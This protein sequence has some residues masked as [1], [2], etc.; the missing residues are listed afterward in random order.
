[1]AG[2]DPVYL[3]DA[4][5][6]SHDGHQI[7]LHLGSHK[8]PPLIALDERTFEALVNYKTAISDKKQEG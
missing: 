7:W 2:R 4:V 3:G 5:Y 1:M 6:A 8:N